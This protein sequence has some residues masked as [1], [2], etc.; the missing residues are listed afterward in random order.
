VYPHTPVKICVIFHSLILFNFCHR[1][2][3]AF[4]Y[5]AACPHRKTQTIFGSLCEGK[6]KL[7]TPQLNALRCPAEFNEA[8]GLA[9]IYTDKGKALSAIAD[10][11]K[12]V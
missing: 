5:A 1:R 4:S 7:G 9:R 12:E 10:F 8:D 3:F 6:R 2:V 11:K